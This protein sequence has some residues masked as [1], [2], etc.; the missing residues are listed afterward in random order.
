MPRCTLTRGLMH[1]IRH[2][3]AVRQEV[4]AA[5]ILIPLA[6][7]LEVSTVQRLFLICSVLLV[8]IIELLNTAI[9]A[10]VD[11]IGLEYNELSGLAKDTG[12]AAVFFGL[13]QCVIV[14]S[15]IMYSL[16]AP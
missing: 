1:N 6:C 14:W 15:I 9:E 10:T 8:I 7:W 4:I 3:A 11:R 2:E 5:L 12:S 16:L 13:L